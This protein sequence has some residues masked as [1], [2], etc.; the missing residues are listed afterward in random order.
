MHTDSKPSVFTTLPGILGGIAA[1]L[2]AGTG[3]YIACRDHSPKPGPIEPRTAST[4][5]A[6]DSLLV[7]AYVRLGKLADQDPPRLV[8]S[9]RGFDLVDSTGFLTV[10]D[11][12]FGTVDTAGSRVPNVFRFQLTLRNTT[13]SDLQ[14]DLTSRFFTLRDNN[15]RSAALRYFCCPSRG[16]LL[17][18]GEAR[19]I[20]L[21]FYSTEWYGKGIGASTLILSVD[22]LLP[23]EH[24]EWRYGTLATAA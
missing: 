2:T 4:A 8:F 13:S 6:A 20:V 16:D 24:G 18:A 10:S 14:L 11:A 19:Q 22:G 12:S 1:L 3:L 7:R 17:R 21:F 23:L 9:S 5:E 15:G